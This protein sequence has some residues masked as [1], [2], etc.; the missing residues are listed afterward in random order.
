MI[1]AIKKAAT[2]LRL[3]DDTPYRSLALAQITQLAK[4]FNVPG[5]TVEITALENNIVPE[6]Y[7]RNLRTLEPREQATLLKAGVCVIGLGG[8]GGGVVELLSRSGIGHLTLI[9]GDQFETSNLNRQLFCTESGLGRKKAA[10]AAE[11][12][13]EINSS[14]TVKVHGE[15]INDHN[16]TKLVGDC[17]VVVDCLDNLPTRF[18]IEAAARYIKAPLVS[19]AVA[20]LSGHITTVFP[21]DAGLTAVYGDADGLPEK[22]VETTLGTFPSAVTTLSALQSNEVVNILL[23]RPKLLRNRLLLMD[24][25]DYTFEI[26]DLT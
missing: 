20:G 21:E 26:L 17:D 4:Q 14:I 22:G 6:R 8:L 11:R 16:A 25:M 10:A 12:V 2:D 19:A 9:E 15:Y 1:D 18:L 13:S 5:S 24:L 7:I 3:P 23:G